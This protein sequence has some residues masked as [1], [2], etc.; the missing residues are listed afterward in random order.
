MGHAHC[1]AGSDDRGKSH[2]RRHVC[3]QEARALHLADD[4]DDDIDDRARLG[5]RRRQLAYASGDESAGFEIDH[6]GLGAGAADVDSERIASQAGVRRW[7]QRI[8]TW[9]GC[10]A[11]CSHGCEDIRRRVSTAAGN[12]SDASSR[13][14]IDHGPDLSHIEPEARA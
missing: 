3:R 13:R 14:A 7:D 8:L 5:G 4:L 10:S 6:A 2:A 1:P 11:R 9:G 12:R